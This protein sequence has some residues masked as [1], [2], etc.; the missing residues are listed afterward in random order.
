MALEKIDVLALGRGN[1]TDNSNAAIVFSANN[2]VAL[3]DSGV[4]YAQYNVVEYSGKVYRSKVASNLANQPD[5]SPNQWETLYIGVKD[6]DIAYVVAGNASDVIQRIGG[7]WRDL[8]GAPVTVALVDGQVSPA[9]ALVFLGSDRSWAKIEYT[10][11]RG[12]GQN[13][14]RKGVYEV[15]NDNASDVEY[16]HA[17]T[18]IGSDI[19][20]SV[21]WSMAGGNVHMQYTSVSEGN[22]IEFKY[23]LKGWS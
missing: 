14:K 2:F 8:G 12:I 10:L 6:G 17:F 9:D 16:S 21:T 20:V 23:T 19:E 22:A 15:L 4:T 11:R 3:W 1:L 7:I 5:T 13:R 18:D